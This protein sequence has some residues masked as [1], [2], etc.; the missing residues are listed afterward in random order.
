MVSCVCARLLIRSRQN[1]QRWQD[2]SSWKSSAFG[3]IADIARAAGFLA[4]ESAADLP[5]PSGN[6]LGSILRPRTEFYLTSQDQFSTNIHLRRITPM[7]PAFFADEY[8][9]RLNHQRF[10]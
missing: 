3:N 9:H 7:P 10:E 2:S 5:R 4:A 1:R 8:R 6:G